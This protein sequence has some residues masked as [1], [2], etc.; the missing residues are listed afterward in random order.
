MNADINEDNTRAADAAA[1]MLIGAGYS[2]NGNAWVSTAEKPASPVDIIS[3]VEEYGEAREG[4]GRDERYAP[5]KEAC[6][7]LARIKVALVEPIVG[8]IKCETD[9]GNGVKAATTLN[10]VRV[11]REDDGTFT[12]VTDHWPLT[13]APPVSPRVLGI[14]CTVAWTELATAMRADGHEIRDS[15]GPNTRGWIESIVR[16]ALGAP[17][18]TAAVPARLPD[19]LRWVAD[20]IVRRD[21]LPGNFAQGSRDTLY[22]RACVI[23]AA[24]KDQ[25]TQ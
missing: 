24:Q 5:G 20:E 1:L 6:D 4:D 10:V 18:P 19:F 17:S 15:S 21:T 8:S 11:E 16:D 3:L 9:W 12:I 25:L 13:V 22:G 2:W 14:A 23:E 7:L